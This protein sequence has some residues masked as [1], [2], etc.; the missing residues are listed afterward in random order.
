[1][2]EEKKH[3]EFEPE[4]EGSGKNEGT[5]LRG[6]IDGTLLTRRKVLRQLPFHTV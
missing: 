1:M 4:S 3:I 6:L 5:I 2:K